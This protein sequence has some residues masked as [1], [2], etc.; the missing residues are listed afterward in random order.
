MQTVTYKFIIRAYHI[1]CLIVAIT[2]TSWC[3][4]EYSMDRDVTEIRL[5]K[6][7]ETNNDIHPSIT[8]CSRSP[9]LKEKYRIYIKNHPQLNISNDNQADAMMG[10]FK[11]FIDSSTNWLKGTA[12]KDQNESYNQLI[13]TLKGIDYDS[14]TI[15]LRDLVSKFTLTVPVSSEQLAYI[16][17]D[18]I[19]D[20]HIASNNESND[21]QLYALQEMKDINSYIS[22]RQPYYKCFTID[23]PMKLQT[24]IREISIKLNTSIFSYGLSLSQFYFTL[25]YPKQFIR[26]PIGSRITIN[27]NKNPQCYKFQIHLGSMKVFKRRDKSSAPCNSD[28]LHHDE[29]QMNYIIRKVGCNPMHWNLIHNMPNCSTAKQYSEINKMFRETK[30][31]MPP[32][33]SIEKLAKF[34]T[35]LDL[36]IRCLTDSYLDLKFYLDEE[37]FYEEV[38]LVPAYDIQHLVGNAGKRFFSKYCL[39]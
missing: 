37:T 21:L 26:T 16:H 30:E 24:D 6:F 2:L 20:S 35:G 23:T 33:R 10:Y 17:Y 36:G 39:F 14:S 3:I 25:T 32:C 5:R 34:T 1:F 38:I 13:E 19:N 18:V 7:H 27:K 9:F 11:S 15:S 12:F 8:I 31:F 22:A 4:Y 28:W 29:K